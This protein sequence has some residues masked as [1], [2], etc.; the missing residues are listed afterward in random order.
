MSSEDKINYDN[1]KNKINIQLETNLNTLE[2]TQGIKENNFDKIKNTNKWHKS[3]LTIA[4]IIK[5][6]LTIIAGYLC[7]N[8]N[9]SENIFLRILFTSVSAVFSEIYILYY[10]VYRVYMGNACNIRGN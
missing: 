3:Q 4:C 5:F 9:S 6:I 2:S 10:A 7:W 8:C 1:D